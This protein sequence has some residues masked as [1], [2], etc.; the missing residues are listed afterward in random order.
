MIRGGVT[1]EVAAVIQDG[2]TLEVLTCREALVAAVA[3]VAGVGAY[4]QR[5]NI[6]VDLHQSLVQDLDLCGDL[7]T[8]C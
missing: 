4:L 6:H 1:L 2:A 3:I 7:G 5:E 8:A